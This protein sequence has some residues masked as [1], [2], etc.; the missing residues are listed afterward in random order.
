MYTPK[1]QFIYN[2][3]LAESPE[4]AESYG[5][6]WGSLFHSYLAD[7]GGLLF[8]SSQGRP[9]QETKTRADLLIR[10][11]RGCAGEEHV[12]LVEDKRVSMESQSDVW[13]VAVEQL[14]QSMKMARAGDPSKDQASN[15]HALYGIV[16]VGRYSRFYVLGPLALTPEGYPGTRLLEFKEDEMEIDRLLREIMGKCIQVASQLVPS[17]LE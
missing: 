6:M 17:K 2:Q 10:S 12:I 11:I 14:A 8:V 1:Y 13:A 3:L 5:V 15:P 16:T 4:D 9:Y 7:D